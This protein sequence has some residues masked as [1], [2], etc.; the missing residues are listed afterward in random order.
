[1]TPTFPELITEY[2]IYLVNNE[3]SKG[4]IKG[5]ISSVSIFHQW[6]SNSPHIPQEINSL[7]P[8]HIEEFFYYRKQQGVGSGA[9]QQNY[10]HLN[11]FFQWVRKRYK[12]SIKKNPLKKIAKP[13]Y[14][15]PHRKFPSRD[16]MDKL[17]QSF[18]TT[19]FDGMRNRFAC[20]VLKETGIRAEELIQLEENRF[21]IQNQ[22]LH[23]IEG[24]GGKNRA[25][26][27]PDIVTVELHNYLLVRSNHT[28][29]YHRKLL[30]NRA[31]QLSYE[32]LRLNIAD[33]CDLIGIEKITPHLF[34]HAFNDYLKKMGFS[35]D[36]IMEI[37]GWD[38]RTMLDHYARYEREG[39]A[40][41]E[42]R[43]KM[44]K[45]E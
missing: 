37:M 15:L 6:L 18:D 38:T 26:P 1:M 11:A 34:R 32:T 25:V 39:R 19:T 12:K 28:N 22:V 20:T 44:S 3:Y 35:E 13:T 8:K 4:T 41:E 31:G 23:I 45:E 7:K 9:R 42:Y 33:Q 5:Y 17:I 43:R 36:A 16:V 40:I 2:R 10:T 29:R 30:L 14:K 24:K 21:D 27:F